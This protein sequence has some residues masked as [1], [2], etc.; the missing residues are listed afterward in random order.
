MRAVNA[1]GS[2]EWARP[3]IASRAEA[4]SSA[5]A[6]TPGSACASAAVNR[7][8][9]PECA[10]PAVPALEDAVPESLR[11]TGSVLSSS[12]VTTI[13]S[14]GELRLRVQL[15]ECQRYSTSPLRGR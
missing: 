6:S 10:L 4:M 5:T 3:L 8:P 14:S 11:S 1:A 13:I 9:P 7:V 2:G 12:S 15:R